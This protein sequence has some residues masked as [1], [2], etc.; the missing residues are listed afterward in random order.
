MPGTVS[1]ASLLFCYLKQGEIFSYNEWNFYSFFSYIY[2]HIIH[3]C[4]IGY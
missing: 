3:L 4:Y 2:Q 1:V